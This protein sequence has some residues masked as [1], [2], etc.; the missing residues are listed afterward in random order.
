[1]ATTPTGAYPFALILNTIKTQVINGLGVGTGFVRVVASDNYKVT[2]ADRLFSYI[3]PFAPIPV[4]PKHG[5][6]LVDIGSG[7]QARVVGRRIRVYIWTRSGEDIYGND[8]VALIGTSP[9]ST[10]LNQSNPIRHFLAEE[11]LLNCL[12][13]YAPLNSGG[14]ICLTIGP[15]HWI[16]TEGGP[17]LR[18]PVDE[19]GLVWSALDFQVVY[20]SAIDNSEPAPIAE[21]IPPTVASTDSPPI[22]LSGPSDIVSW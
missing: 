10:V 3:R 16:D 5:G 14:T 20:L 8:Q 19:E 2:R 21:G 15:V 6:G 1:M 7:R 12:D 18:K 4:N 17:P 9:S 22:L 13:D 11:L